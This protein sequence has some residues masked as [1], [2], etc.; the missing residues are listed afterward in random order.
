M[1]S[2]IITKVE[3]HETSRD[4][5]DWIAPKAMTAVGPSTCDPINSVTDIEYICPQA[6]Y[7][8]SGKK[9][10][11][12]WTK[13]VGEV[14]GIP[15]EVYRNMDERLQEQDKDLFNLRQELCME[16]IQS[17]ELESEMN[18]HA[19]K[20]RDL[21]KIISTATFKERAAYALTGYMKGV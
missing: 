21:K 20:V 9:V 5:F 14:L 2:K 11:I 4:T 16:R 17:S 10:R 8:P 18:V 6:F 7:L 19:E 15:L 13:E 3:V 12:G 1:Q